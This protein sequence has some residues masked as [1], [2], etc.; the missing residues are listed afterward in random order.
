MVFIE[1]APQPLELVVDRTPVVLLEPP[2]SEVGVRRAG[3]SAAD[4]PVWLP[5]PP[6]GAAH[7]GGRQVESVFRAP[8]LALVAAA[9][10]IAGYR[11]LG[12]IPS[13]GS[14]ASSLVFDR[15]GGLVLAVVIALVALAV[16][17]PAAHGRTVAPSAGGAGRPHRGDREC[18]AGLG[19][20]AGIRDAL[21][22]CDLVLASVIAVALVIDERSRRQA[23][24][25]SMSPSAAGA[26]DRQLPVT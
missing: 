16:T 25:T 12:V 11:W 22:V 6:I 8:A 19:P 7:P 4:P 10:I 17:R 23:E 18:R 5:R 20:G 21:G 3:A 13:S 1:I 24:H 15:A 9:A 2:A 26:T 14:R